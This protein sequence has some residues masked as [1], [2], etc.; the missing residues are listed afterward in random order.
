MDLAA[1]AA[2]KQHGLLAGSRELAARQARVRHEQASQPACRGISRG[3]Q[4]PL[5]A[6]LSLGRHDEHHSQFATPLCAN[7]R[8]RLSQR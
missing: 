2:G 3:W 6:K 5:H 4:D 8:G 1:I 7:A